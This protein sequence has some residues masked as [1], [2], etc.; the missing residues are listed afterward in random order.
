MIIKLILDY[1]NSNDNELMIKER[2]VNTL[3]FPDRVLTG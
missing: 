3:G 2:V 1:D